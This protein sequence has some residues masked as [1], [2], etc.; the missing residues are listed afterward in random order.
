MAWIAVVFSALWF[1]NQNSVITDWKEIAMYATIIVFEDKIV[2]TTRNLT[3]NII[4]WLIHLQVFSVNGVTAGKFR[5]KA[6]V[7]TAGR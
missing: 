6:A 3:L 4:N 1:G 7:T 5:R 2:G